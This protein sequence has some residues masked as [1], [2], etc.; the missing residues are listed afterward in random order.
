M[1][2]DQL[3][4]YTWHRIYASTVEAERDIR[5]NRS[6]KVEIGSLEIC[7]SRTADGYFAVQDACPHLGESLSKGTCNFL[8]EVVCPWHSYRFSLITGDET[9]SHGLHLKTY[10]VQLTESG[11]YLALPERA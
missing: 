4:N 11:L 3:P 10:P 1:L 6:R 8:N 2:P 9:T 5:L 7:L